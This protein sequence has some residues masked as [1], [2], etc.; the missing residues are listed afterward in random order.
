MAEL[1]HQNQELTREIN[2]RRQRHER[3]M[4]G[5]AQSQEVREGENV[6]RKNHLRGTIS[7]RVPYL[8]RKMDE[9]R[10]AMEEMSENIRRM[11]HVDDLVHR[12][13]SLFIASINSQLL[14]SKFK[15]PSLDSY[16]G[17]RNLCDHIATF[18]TTMHLQGVPNEIMC[19][20]FPTTLKGPGQV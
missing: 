3:C 16:D 2:Q 19:R 5:Q 11:N 20:A 7:R 12:T 1:T 10:R 18:K 9:M 4:E 17:T 14:P 6:E 13:D 8:E 15:M